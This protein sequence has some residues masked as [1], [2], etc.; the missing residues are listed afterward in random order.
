M[1]VLKILE[2]VWKYVEGEGW[3]FT[4]SI[5]YTKNIHLVGQH[6]VPPQ[7]QHTFPRGELGEA[8]PWRNFVGCVAAVG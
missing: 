7:C 3:R 6:S 2:L 4:L 1:E 5:L 8:A